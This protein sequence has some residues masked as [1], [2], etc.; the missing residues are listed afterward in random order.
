MVTL[1]ACFFAVTRYDGISYALQQ[2]RKDASK[3]SNRLG[4]TLGS[5]GRESGPKNAPDIGSD[6][7]GT[8]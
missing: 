7:L 6:V 4:K 3:L 5:L 1:F 2:S 8:F